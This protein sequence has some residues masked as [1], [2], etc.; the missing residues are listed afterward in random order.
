MAG[1]YKGVGAHI[2]NQNPRAF[3]VACAAHSLN[4]CIWRKFFSGPIIFR[5]D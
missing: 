5:N 2:L 3:V 4:F 1:L